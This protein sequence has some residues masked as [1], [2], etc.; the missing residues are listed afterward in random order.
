[1]GIE[2]TK[3]DE[4]NMDMLQSYKSALEQEL[5]SVNNMI[6]TGLNVDELVNHQKKVYKSLASNYLLISSLS[7]TVNPLDLIPTETEFEFNIS[8]DDGVYKLICNRQIFNN[9]PVYDKYQIWA[10]NRERIE[11]EYKY[12]LIKATKKTSTKIKTFK[13]PVAVLFVQHYKDGY[14]RNKI[15]IDNFSTKLFIDAVIVKGG[16]VLDDNPK[17][18]KTFSIMS[19]DDDRDYT[20]VFVGD[21]HSVLKKTMDLGGT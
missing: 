2:L 13:I 4:Q 6:E 3:T 11:G 5:A 7:L 21:V 14:S 16:F 1:M 19:V 15:D 9:P 20:E 17:Y 12:A 18:I 8:E 10:S